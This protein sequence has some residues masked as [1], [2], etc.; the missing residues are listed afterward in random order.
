MQKSSS[1][2]STHRW[3]SPCVCAAR[4]YDRRPGRPPG[5]HDGPGSKNLQAC[6]RVVGRGPMG[7]PILGRGAELCMF[8]KVKLS[9]RASAA[10]AQRQRSL[11]T[12]RWP[13]KSRPAVELL[14]CRKA[15]PAGLHKSA[16]RPQAGV[17]HAV[18]TDVRASP[19]GHDDPGVKKL[20]ACPRVVGRG[21]M[22]PPIL[23]RAA[24]LCVFQKVQLSKRARSARVQSQVSLATAW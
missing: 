3:A 14:R 19:G 4:R 22:G 23:G 8:Q 17:Q 12:A 16:G 2:R 9:K 20:P 13:A 24:E 7:P 15:P 21:P 6:P 10:R 11:A 1:G 18:M 5:G